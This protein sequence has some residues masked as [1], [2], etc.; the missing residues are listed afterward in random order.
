MVP[1]VVLDE[2]GVA[3]GEVVEAGS[4]NA[5]ALAVYRG[6]ADFG[7]TF[8][9]PYLKPEGEGPWEEGVDQPDIPEEEVPNCAVTPEDRLFCGDYRVLD[10]RASV[11]TWRS[12]S[13]VSSPWEPNSEGLGA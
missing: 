10:A 5:A 12:A 2:A 4:H 3:P 1:S 13:A 7:T 8:Y 6:E 9:S 11:R